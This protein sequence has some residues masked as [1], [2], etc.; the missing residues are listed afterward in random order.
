[1]HQDSTLSTVD[2][3]W[4]VQSNI[5]SVLKP[6]PLQGM[7]QGQAYVDE[8][9]TLVVPVHPKPNTAGLVSCALLNHSW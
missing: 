9:G 3:P 5:Y 8:G 6:S 7:E 2:W 4:V 1:M